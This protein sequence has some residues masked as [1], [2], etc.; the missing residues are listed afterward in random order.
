MLRT[1]AAKITGWLLVAVF[2]L[3][4]AFYVIHP[5]ATDAMAITECRQNYARARNKSDTLRIDGIVPER[6]PR[7]SAGVKCGELRRAYPEVTAR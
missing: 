5:R 3:G 7:A 4:A 1:Q 6:A 2:V